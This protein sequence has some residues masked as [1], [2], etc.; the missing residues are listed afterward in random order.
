MTETD[1]RPTPLQPDVAHKLLDL[2]ATDDGFRELFKKDP[3]AALVQVGHPTEDAEL[4]ASQL[5]VDALADKTA[6]AQ[7]R[8]DIHTSLTSSANMQPIR[9]NVPSGSSPQLKK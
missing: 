3:K 9:L 6:I 4:L 7:A 1:K 8:D 2:L 5:K